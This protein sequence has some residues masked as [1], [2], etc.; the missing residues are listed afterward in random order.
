MPNGAARTDVSGGL[1]PRVFGR[2]LRHVRRGLGLTLED[3]A[4]RVGRSAPYLSQIENGHRVPNL[5]LASRLATGVGVPLEE[6]L[7]PEA[8][9]RR[10]ELEMRYARMVEEPLF[11]DLGLPALTVSARVPDEALEHVIGLFEALQRERAVRTATPEEARRANLLLREEMRARGNYFADIESVARDALIAVDHAGPGAPSPQTVADLVRHLGF[12]VEHVADLPSAMRSL[13]DL[14]GRRILIPQ[15]N[16]LDARAARSV[17]FQTLAHQALEH[18]QPRDVH[19]FLRQRVEVNYFAGAILVP[20]AS[21]APYLQA[22]KARNDLSVEDL[23]EAYNVS[24]EMAGHRFTNLATRHLDL[25]V[26][27]IRSDEHG[28][29]WKAY[30]NN[31]VPFNRDVSGAVEGQRLCRNWGTRRVFDTPRSYDIHY[32]YTE[33]PK[34]MFWCATYLEVDRE[35]QHAVTVGTT[36]SG[37]KHFRGRTTL[38]RSTSSCPDPACCRRPTSEQAERWGGLV[39]PSPRPHSHL[40]ASMPVGV[41]PGVDLLEVYEFLDSHPPTP[42]TG[43]SDGAE[44]TTPVDGSAL[45]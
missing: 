19:E 31:D 22:A 18:S 36:F 9:D 10:S 11:R 45:P 29:V 27:F 37:A 16:E 26:H 21:A 5:E 6:L 42:S 12:R 7:V 30:E 28:V 41:F 44:D 4:T 32:Q 17:I 14:R 13:A 43:P 25:A 40:L 34:G 3:L 23:A 2:R 8:P 33:T 24:Y 38:A 35:P 15:R 1:D 39:W 20:E